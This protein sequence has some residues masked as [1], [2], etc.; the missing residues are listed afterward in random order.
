MMG[1]FFAYIRTVFS[2]FW[3]QITIYLPV[4]SRKRETSLDSAATV[5]KSAETS[6]QVGCDPSVGKKSPTLQEEVFE[7]RGR[8][9]NV[10]EGV[11]KEREETAIDREETAIDRE[12][13]AIDRE[14]TAI[15]R[16]ET[17][18]DREETAIDIKETRDMQNRLDELT[19]AIVRNGLLAGVS[20]SREGGSH[21]ANATVEKIPP[22][23]VKEGSTAAITAVYGAEKAE[24]ILGKNVSEEHFSSQKEG[25]SVN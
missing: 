9:R 11:A 14:E 18:I 2:W 5:S 7:M 3:E 1:L 13:T 19:E 12:E 16:E 22:A 6:V 24:T 10:E 25:R 23:D 4:F 8:L 15:D 17:A 20:A 21:A